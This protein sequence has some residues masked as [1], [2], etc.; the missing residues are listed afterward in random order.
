MLTLGE[1]EHNRE[2]TEC[3]RVVKSDFGLGLPWHWLK[4]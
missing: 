4:S 1:T 2:V 3:A